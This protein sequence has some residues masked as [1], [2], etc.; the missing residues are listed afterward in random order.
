MVIHEASSVLRG[1]IFIFNL[2]LL[3]RSHMNY[4]TFLEN[5]VQHVSASVHNGQKVV[6]QPV[7][8]N[9]GMVYDGLVIMDPGLN[10]SPTIYLNPYYHRFLNGVSM[11]DIY[12]DI[13]D[14][15]YKNLPTKDFDIS[16]FRDFDK[17]SKMIA[18]KLINKEK[19][20][21]LLD[22]VPYV[23]FQDLA[24][25]F[26][27]I[28]NNFRKEFATILI[29]NQHLHLW[30]IDIETLYQ[31][32]L[33]N[34]PKLL[35]YKFENL[36]HLIFKGEREILS[37]LQDFDMYIL[38]NKLKIHGATCMVYPRL[39]KRISDFLEDNLVIIPSSIHEVLIIPESFTKG[40]YSM[41][42]FKIMI[43]EANETTL[44]DDEILADHAYFFERSTG[45]LSY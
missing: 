1:F 7:I 45:T 9:N 2:K 39:L 16:S 41:D 30:E 19:N 35:S 5:V 18:F 22:D 14:T 36:E 13:L 31:I 26:V 20:K 40:E 33:E 12:K 27:C 24:L 34:T 44:T 25:V 38:T 21:I 29:H 37:E 32:A 17:A 15:Y 42:D 43:T 8:K 3:R 11:D 28:V 23:E 4:Q 6:L 10:I